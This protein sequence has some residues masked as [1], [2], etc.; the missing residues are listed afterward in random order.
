MDEYLEFEGL[1]KVAIIGMSCRFPDAENTEEFWNNLVSGKE[2]V[3][4]FTDKELYSS[5]V[6][7]TLVDDPSYVKAFCIL[8]NI[9]QFDASF[10]DYSEEE[11]ELIDPQH[12]I[13]L[14]CAYEAFEDAGYIPQ[15]YDGNIGVY[16]GVRASG[17]TKV[18]AP[19]L[20][21]TG[22][23]K[24][25][26]AVLGTTVDQACLRISHALNLKG[27]SIG[28]QT[29]CSAS[30]VAVHMACESLRNREC[31]MA[32]AG[33]S[34]IFVPE[35]Q[36]YLY[37]RKMIASPDGHCRAFDKKAN[38]VIGGNGIGTV[39]LKRL[40]DAVKDKDNIYAVIAGSA[41]NND[42]SMK[43]DYRA[44]NIEGQQRVIEDAL[45]LSNVDPLSIS[46]VEGHG[47]GTFLGDS[48]EI[49]A[50]TRAFRSKTD[51][52]YFCALGSVK[53][54]IG[55]LTQAAGIAS[56]IKTVL[57]VK[58][59]TIPKSLNCIEPN[60]QLKDSPFFVARDNIDWKL[61]NSKRRALINSFAIGGTNAAL[62]LEEA[63]LWDQLKNN[64]KFVE[65]GYFL[66]TISTKTKKSLINLIKRYLVYLDNYSGSSIEDICFT[67]S[68]GR[69]H[70]QYRLALLVKSIE[71]LKFRLKKIDS[72]KYSAISSV[73]VAKE[74][75]EIVFVFNESE[76]GVNGLDKKFY[77]TQPLYRNF[78]DRCFK[79]LK[80]KHNT[81]LSDY[82]NNSDT[83]RKYSNILNFIN[84]CALIEIFSRLNIRPDFVTGRGNG[85][86][87]A[88]FAS[89]SLNLEQCLDIVFSK[90]I[91]FKNNNIKL[92]ELLSKFS[93]QNAE[94]KFF[95]LTENSLIL[96]ENQAF[97]FQNWKDVSEKEINMDLIE[98][99]F[100]K[101]PPPKKIILIC[102]E[103]IIQNLTN[104]NL[105]QKK[106]RNY[107]ICNGRDLS[108]EILSVIS[109]IYVN[110]WDI[111][112]KDFYEQLKYRRVSIPT[113][114][115]DRK[116]CWFQE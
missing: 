88:A 85:F 75:I 103:K 87:L 30:I 40:D 31:E 99:L 4:F 15:T 23:L 33:A 60:P 66:F 38:G 37:D 12:R 115:F 62:V 116:K 69:P 14:E 83:F 17:Y 89:C 84:S 24:C 34:A 13:F 105:L 35:K 113:Y 7:Q 108:E 70:Y 46:Y 64:E 97:D 102:F 111:N 53:T 56:L 96:N 29:A 20:K 76:A 73:G 2:S 61:E 104:S 91:K 45:I 67:A 72:Q 52:K 92:K 106:V 109:E 57:S 44:P 95:S 11:A 81:D 82:F 16:G 32:L 43:V 65:P 80:T 78:I 58:N 25:F 47:T 48:I 94:S 28:I 90:E 74:N 39:L 21:K 100:L 9:D 101:N 55:H 50:L 79:I 41:V 54:N 98:S 107:S 42:G 27:P 6:D 77:H 110:G 36:G 18:L 114:P 10:F 93:L 86:F 49:E 63:P 68:V 22:T 26:E 19:V 3:S 51:N 112:F 5:G 1:E 8:N 59:C 71:D